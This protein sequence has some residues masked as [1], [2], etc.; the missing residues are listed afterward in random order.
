MSKTTW[1]LL[2]EY[3]IAF[4]V[5][6][7]KYPSCSDIC[8]HKWPLNYPCTVNENFPCP[9]KQRKYGQGTHPGSDL[10]QIRIM[11]RVRIAKV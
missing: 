3:L 8:L 11:K 1:N 6:S 4:T 2:I 10:N 5:R 9:L 7:S